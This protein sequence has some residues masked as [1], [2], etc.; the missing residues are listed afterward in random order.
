MKAEHVNAFLVPAV[1]VISKMAKI[2]VKLD[3]PTKIERD[4]MPQ[5][6]TQLSTIIGISGGMSGSVTL[7]ASDQSAR[8]L[9][10]KIIS[11]D[12]ET[13]S[14]EDIHAIFSEIANTIAGNAAGALYDLG[15]KA[16]ITPPTLVKGDCITIRFLE[17]MD[18]INIPILLDFGRLDLRV[19][20][21]KDKK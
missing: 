15:V 10:A 2:D 11:E 3:K 9:C 4:M 21:T 17:G 5:E 7:S 20:F 8:T 14:E 12:P 19:A 1:N 18:I 6:S 16:D 13:I